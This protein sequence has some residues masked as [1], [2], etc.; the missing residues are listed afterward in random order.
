M[1]ETTPKPSIP[2]KSPNDGP[3]AETASF[4]PRHQDTDREA[5]TIPSSGQTGEVVARGIP[6]IPG[7]EIIS[8]IGRGGMG[9][10]YKAR[11]NKLKRIV[12]L[13]MVLAGAR[14]SPDDLIRFRREAEA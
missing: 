3:S 12:A 10:I 13:K 2:A 6:T 14:A 11:Q 4:S 9:V 5:A 7:Y 1:N 8:E